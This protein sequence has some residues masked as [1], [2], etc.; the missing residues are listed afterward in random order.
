MSDVRAIV[1]AAGQ[2][3]RMKST[4]PKVLHQVL[5]KPILQRVLGAILQAFG[6][7][8]SRVHVIVGHSADVVRGFVEQLT[9][10]G[11]RDAAMP[12]ET[13]LQ[14]PQ[15]GTGHAVMQAQSGLAGFKGTVFVTVGD[16]PVIQ[17]RTLSA[18]L[19]HHRASGAA[20]TAL[21]ANIANPHGYGRMVR[22]AHGAI[23]G[24]VEEKDATDE[25][26]KITE[27]NTGIYC[28]EWPAMEAGLASLSCD[29]KQKEYYLTDLISWAY[30]QKM[31]T[32]S[33]VLDDYREVVGINS[34]IE[35]A[36]AARH[37]RDITNARLSLESGVT[38]FDPQ[39]TF[40]A[41]EVTIGEETVI[42]PGCTLQG[43]IT[44][45]RDCVIGPNTIIK[46]KCSVGDGTSIISSFV[47]DSII[48]QKAKI[49][50]F[51]HLREG[52][53][54]GDSAKV[55]NFVE[56]KKAVLG[57]KA[58]CGHLSYIGDATL[59]DH[60]NIGAGTITA[61]YDHL[62]KQKSRTIIE[63]G[64]STGSNSVLVAPVTV[65]AEAVVAA[66]T[67]VTDDVPK[68]ALAVGRTRQKNLEGWSDKRRKAHLSSS[69]IPS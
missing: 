27:V 21:T 37:L 39:S 59:G 24:I 15:L 62:T 32:E 25:E 58:S 1:L 23:K 53:T 28:L 66:G 68:G 26:R 36:E 6:G 51:A 29:N 3:K 17:A 7:E 9:A 11:S 34:R 54:V 49:G 38:I 50:P 20:I 60:V 63:D 46:G 5:G 14:E 22:D 19:D 64:A 10:S 30:G 69:G 2:G 33:L 44:I 48:G 13:H 52:N 45:G 56:L 8:L 61:N 16:A 43:D 67:S 31:Q 55:G 40:I 12:I 41:P 18:L 35:L 4:T 47:N 65:G 57:T 42:M